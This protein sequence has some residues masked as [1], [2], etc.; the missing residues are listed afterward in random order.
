VS[1]R[2]LWAFV[3]AVAA[4]RRPRRVRADPEDAALLR[5][6][7]DLR[8]ARPGAGRPGERFVDDLHRRLADRLAE[9]AAQGPPPRSHRARTALAAVAAGA[10]LVAG[11]VAVTEATDPAAP[12]ASR[13]PRADMLRTGTFVGA[14]H[15]VLGQIVAYHGHP[16]WVFMNVAVPHYDGSLTC[17]LQSADGSVVAFGTFRVHH[18]VGQFSTT[19]R[20]RVGTLRGARLVTSSGSPVASATFA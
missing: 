13:P 7:I 2:R 16:G 6:A 20:V 18:G 11:T 15:R 17:E 4:G 8:A 5:T 3:D 10:A 14:D 1:G 12:A 9:P 19:I